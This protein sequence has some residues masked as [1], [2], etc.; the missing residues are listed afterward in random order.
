MD[1]GSND[2]Q[3]WTFLLSARH[4]KSKRHLSPTFCVVHDSR[5]DFTLGDSSSNFL[6][7]LVP[8][9]PQYCA[10]KFCRG[11]HKGSSDCSYDTFVMTCMIMKR[12]KHFCT[13]LSQHI[14]CIVVIPHI[15]TII[16]IGCHC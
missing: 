9:R 11:G 8:T 2:F 6:F 13:I 12:K 5:F 3:V 14:I 4:R 1:F 15:I 7:L 16:A 10:A